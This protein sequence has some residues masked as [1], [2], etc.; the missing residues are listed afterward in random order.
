MLGLP[1][2]QPRIPRDFSH[3]SFS[4]EGQAASPSP[5]IG[6]H[7]SIAGLHPGPRT[8]SPRSTALLGAR[9]PRRPRCSSSEP[10]PQTTAPQRVG[11]VPAQTRRQRRE[12]RKGPE[13][14]VRNPLLSPSASALLHPQVTH[15]EWL[16]AKVRNL[17]LK[18]P[19]ARM[20]RL[21]VPPTVGLHWSQLR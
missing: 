8:F 1:G 13:P 2:S 17:D 10:L 19:N 3:V 5:G 21:L 12:P 20:P 16:S 11:R 18:K 15:L 14:E 6:L 4:T 9:Q 7:G